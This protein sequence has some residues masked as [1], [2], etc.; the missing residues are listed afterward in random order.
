MQ[1]EFGPT[2]NCQSACLAMLL[3]VSLSDVPNFAAMDGD[4]NLKY[5]AQAK[6]L[7]DRGWALITI[8]KWQTLPWPPTKGFYIAGG[9]SP[10]GNR[11]SVIY[12][13]GE[14]WHDPHHNGGGIKSVDDIDILY[15]LQPFG[16]RFKPEAEEAIFILEDTLGHDLSRFE[17]GQCLNAV[18]VLKKAIRE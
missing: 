9:V 11:H 3:G 4:D 17:L 1:T 7:H 16:R 18:A 8:V 10:R 5:I 14:L 12:H 13:D 15:Q 6:W 2:G